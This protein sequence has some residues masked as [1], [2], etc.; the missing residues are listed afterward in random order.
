MDSAEKESRLS[1]LFGLRFFYN[2]VE[3]FSNPRLASAAACAAKDLFFECIY[4]VSA[5]PD[6]RNDFS[7]GYGHA[8]TDEIVVAHIHPIGYNRFRDE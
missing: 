6:R 4:R 3:N 7:A 5:V 8:Y 2:F 1:G